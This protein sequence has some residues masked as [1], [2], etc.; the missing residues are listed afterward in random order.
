MSSSSRC[1]GA[2]GVLPSRFR[3]AP[4]IQMPLVHACTDEPTPKPLCRPASWLS[5]Y[6][7][8]VRYTPAT[9]HTATVPRSLESEARASSVTRSW[10]VFGSSWMNGCGALMIEQAPV[11]RCVKHR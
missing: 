9:A 11:H 3:G 2:P 1:L 4:H 8:P 5:T 10:P 6:D 7:L